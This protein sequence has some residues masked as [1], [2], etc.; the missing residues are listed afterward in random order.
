[1]KVGKSVRLGRV[2]AAALVV[3][4]SV[5]MPCWVAADGDP[6][7]PTPKPVDYTGLF[8]PAEVVVEAVATGYLVLDATTY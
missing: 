1:M 8:A 5:L 3:L 4:G 6:D 7:P 2:V